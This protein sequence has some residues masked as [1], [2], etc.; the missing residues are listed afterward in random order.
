[1]VST[2]CGSAYLFLVYLNFDCVN[3][4][5]SICTS[6]MLRKGLKVCVNAEGLTCDTLNDGSDCGRPGISDVSTSLSACPAGASH[7]SWL[8]TTNS[9]YGVPMDARANIEPFL[10]SLLQPMIAVEISKMNRIFFIV[11]YIF[12]L[13]CFSVE[14][15]PQ[16][17]NI[18]SPLDARMVVNMPLLVR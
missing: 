14:S 12:L 1:M 4:A 5:G 8:H 6:I 15:M 11:C 17:A 2:I 18:S 3:R 7:R 9:S 13:L 16:A 10:L